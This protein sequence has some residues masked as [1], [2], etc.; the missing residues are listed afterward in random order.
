MLVDDSRV[1]NSTAERRL[2]SRLSVFFASRAVASSRA[3][4]FRVSRLRR[5]VQSLPRA[6]PSAVKA[7]ARPRAKR[8]LH[9][10]ISALR[11]GR[12]DQ[13]LRLNPQRSI[14]GDQVPVRRLVEFVVIELGRRTNHISQLF[15]RTFKLRMSEFRFLTP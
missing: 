14:L 6:P 5:S 8:P 9:F 12:G 11:T 7:P 3:T 1:V 13:I 2:E 4:V 15:L 10:N